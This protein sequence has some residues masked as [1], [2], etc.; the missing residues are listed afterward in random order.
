MEW[1]YARLWATATA[2]AHCL[3]RNALLLNN[4]AG[5]ASPPPPPPP[6]SPLLAPEHRSYTIGV[7]V[8]EGPGMALAVGPGRYCS[9][10]DS[11]PLNPIN[12]G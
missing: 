1:S 3:R 6:L 11:I 8:E 7:M 4:T 5:T 9:P 12:E 2:A 10:R